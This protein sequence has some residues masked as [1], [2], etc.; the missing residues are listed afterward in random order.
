MRIITQLLALLLFST[1]LYAQIIPSNRVTT[2]QPGVTYNGISNGAGGGIPNRTTIYK[3]LSPSGGD[4]TASIQAALNGC[5]ANQVV[6]LTAGVFQINGNGLTFTS[7]NCTL[8]GA[9][10]G[11]G[12]STGINGVATQDSAGTFVPD[13]TATQ[14]IKADRATNA[15][16]GILSIG[17]DPTQFSSSINLASDAVQ[18]A[19][20][21]TLVSNPGI[22]VGQIVLVDM[23]TDTNSAIGC[24][25]NGSDVV[26][27][28]SFGP[29]G[30]GSRRWFIRQDRSLNQIMEVTAV[31]GTTITFAT[32]L[33]YT[34]QTANQAQVSVYTQPVMHGIGVENMFFYG[35]MGGDWHGNVAM[36]LCAYCW[37]KNIEAFWSVGTSV[38]LYGTYR[39]ELRDSYIHETPDA[40]PGGAGY[41]TGLNYGASDN[42]FEN[43]IMWYGN[44]EIVMRGTG[45]GNVVAYNYM[46][47]AFDT[48]N[49]IEPEAGVNAGHYTTPHMELLE[50]N[51]SHNYKGDTYWG[52]SIYITV[53]RNHLSG[54][55]AASR[56]LN[57]YVYNQGSCSYP[58]IDINGRLAVDVQ[59]YSFYTNFVG[60]VLG[61]DG[62]TLLTVSNT[63][64]CY[65]GV[66]DQF[67]FE[68]LT[69]FPS[70][71]PVYMWQMGSY[72]A[73]VNTTGNWSW[74]ANTYQTQLR[75]GNWDWVT[76]TQTW[77]GLGGTQSSP[78][79]SPQSIPNSMYL[80]SAPAFFG[81]S[82]WPWVDPSTGTVYTL[83]AKARFQA[84]I[85]NKAASHDFN[86]DGRSDIAW[87]D[88]SGDVVVW[89]MYGTAAN[90]SSQPSQIS[91]VGTV[92]VA[93]WSIVGQRDFNGNG[94]A[95]LLWHDTSGDVAIWFMNGTQITQAAGVGNASPNVWS[96]V[97]TGDFNG[98]GMG[99][100]LWQDKSGDVAIWFMNGAQVTQ[101]GGIGN[102]SPSV[103]KIVGTGDF[104]GDGMTDILWQDASGDVA[105]WFMNGTQVT[106]AA[107]IGNAS[108][109]AWK[110]VG[111]GDFN[112]D[113]MTDILW[114]DPSGDVAIWFMNGTQ[115]TQTAGVGNVPPSV[116]SIVETG[117]FNGDGKSDILWQDTA[118]DV[119]IWFMNGTQVAQTAG[120]GNVPT[121]VWM[122]H[123]VNADSLPSH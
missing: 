93:V 34:F 78:L 96:V 111:T 1:T 74:V 80:T 68:N 36:Q 95:D 118:G 14:L 51:Y 9:G 119:A 92:P 89:L 76:Q 26:W 53:F 22:Q 30:D 81:S 71:N 60:N 28:P 59:A 11:Q 121:S 73:T 84:I 41:L 10:P 62:Q 87:R 35:G 67:V 122:I 113:G 105:I 23:C 46:D 42:L 13:A 6:L 107:G 27:G 2:W 72:Q 4:D 56:P 98:D 37:I 120:L 83:P 31:N 45:G 97:G 100:I 19:N 18:G 39:S 25:Y 50:G 43:N 61:L 88:A 66:Q 15:N 40:N 47:D 79:G 5:P 38:G 8:R 109:S 115:I 70:D 85:H 114:Q 65:N 99:D 112:G 12:L 16:Y 91:T 103:W 44:K 77:L 24:T 86:G 117:D 102:A 54:L 101:A 21:L 55:R 63:N 104:N 90:P 29:P 52:N 49:P 64:S 32:P 20:S 123:N 106:Q 94:D 3:T 7:P 57:G 17:N 48:T 33:H 82:T 58:Y 108:P 116:W 75:Q 110:I 69:G